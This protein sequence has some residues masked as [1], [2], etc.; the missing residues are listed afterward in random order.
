MQIQSQTKNTYTDEVISNLQ[1]TITRY[2]TRTLNSGLDYGLDYGLNFGLDLVFWN[3]SG[4]PTVQV[5]YVSSL[6]P[7]IRFLCIFSAYILGLRPRQYIR[8]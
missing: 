3:F 8:R 4:L 7:K 5:L 2:K 1:S 6:V